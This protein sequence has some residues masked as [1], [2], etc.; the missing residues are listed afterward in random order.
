MAEPTQKSGSICFKIT[1]AV[2]TTF[3]DCEIEWHIAFVRSV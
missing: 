1:P 3:L 2:S